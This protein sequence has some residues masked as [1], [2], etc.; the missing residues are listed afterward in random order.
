[1]KNKYI[2]NAQTAFLRDTVAFFHSGNRAMMVNTSECCY[3]PTACSPGC[4]IGRHMPNKEI[5]ASL[6]D[7]VNSLKRYG[8]EWVFGPLLTLGLDFLADVQY[9]HDQSR[10]W[11]G[12]GMNEEGYSEVIRICQECGLESN[13]VLSP[14]G[15]TNR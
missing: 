10:F 9:L 7:G 12:C 2:R 14:G 8:G 13:Q 11:D 15:I 4:A 5:C 3:E 6:H 1:M